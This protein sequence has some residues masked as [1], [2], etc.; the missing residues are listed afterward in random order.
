MQKTLMIIK[1]DAFANKSVGKII[2]RVEEEGF[3]LLE[4]K[5]IEMSMEFAKKFYEMHKG[6]VFYEGL[7][8]FMTSGPSF[9][10]VLRKEN[11]IKDLRALVG[12][13]DSREAEAGTLRA[14]FGTD[15]RRNAVHASDSV[16]SALREIALF[17]E[18][19]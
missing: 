19:L 3:E 1:P 14:D 8:Q 9:M 18:A 15:N 2:A 12:T 6:K 10:I 4:A 16:G 13:T 5:M 17:H 7:I 11:A